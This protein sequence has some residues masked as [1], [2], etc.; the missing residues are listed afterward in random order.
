MWIDGRTKCGLGESILK[1]SLYILARILEL[2][3]TLLL[4]TTA[5]ISAT[6]AEG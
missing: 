2:Q 1:H 4:Q 3:D 6:E 5:Q